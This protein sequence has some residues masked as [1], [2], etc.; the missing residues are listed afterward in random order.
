[1]KKLLVLAL[2]AA[3]TLALAGN[4]SAKDRNH[5]KH[6]DRECYSDRNYN[7]YYGYAPVRYYAPPRPYYVAPRYYTPYGNRAPGFSI[8]FSTGR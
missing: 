6:Y 4:A 8:S 2:A 1:M 5:Y 7:R 3:A